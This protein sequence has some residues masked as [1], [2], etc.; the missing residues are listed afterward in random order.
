MNIEKV[1]TDERIFG[2]DDFAE[3]ML[4]EADR[5]ARRSFPIWL[6]DREVSQLIEEKCEREGISL[7]EL[8]MGIHRGA[9]PE[10]RSDLALK[11]ARER[12]RTLAEI[13]RQLGVSTSAISHILRRRLGIQLT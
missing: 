6:R 5:R 2:T 3:G 10:I 11:L 4:G 9:M 13:A 12:G 7:R 8:Q 1:L